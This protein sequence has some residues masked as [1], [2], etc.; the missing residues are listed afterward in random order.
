MSRQRNQKSNYG[1]P[2]LANRDFTSHA[3]QL[4]PLREDC[5]AGRFCDAAADRNV[6]PAIL[7]VLHP[8]SPPPDVVQRL[9]QRLLARRPENLV[10]CVRG[11]RVKQPLRGVLFMLEDSQ[12]SQGPGLVA[13]ARLA[14]QG[15]GDRPHPLRNVVVVDNALPRQPRTGARM[16]HIMGLCVSFPAVSFLEHS[17]TPL[18]SCRFSLQVTALARCDRFLEVIEPFLPRLIW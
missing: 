11:R 1:E 5:L 16:I 7:R 13:R 14:E 9:P 2:Q 12:H 10:L 18:I 15:F 3:G 4:Q 17:L 8:L 6:P